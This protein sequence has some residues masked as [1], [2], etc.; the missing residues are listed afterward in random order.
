MPPRYCDRRRHPRSEGQRPVPPSLG[1]GAK[2]QGRRSGTSDERAIDVHVSP[3]AITRRVR[4]AYD[5]L[6]RQVSAFVAEVAGALAR[7]GRAADRLSVR[8][9]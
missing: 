6:V 9:R 8:W 2:R 4:L 1:V 3:I 5:R 7:R